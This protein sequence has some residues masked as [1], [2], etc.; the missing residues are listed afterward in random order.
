MTNERII[1]SKKLA[2]VLRQQGFKLLRT[3][4]NENHPQFITYIFKDDEKLQA[5]INEYSKH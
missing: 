3:G 1:Y 4:I 5:A 2:L